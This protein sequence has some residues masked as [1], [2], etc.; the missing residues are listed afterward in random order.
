MNLTELERNYLIDLVEHD[1]AMY[2]YLDLEGIDKEEIDNL[3]N[4]LKRLK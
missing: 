1:I 2:E 4:R 3:L